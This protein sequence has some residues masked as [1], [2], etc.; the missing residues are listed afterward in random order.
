MVWPVQD[1]MGVLMSISP[2]RRILYPLLLVA[3]WGICFA[4]GIAL[5]S[6]VSSLTVSASTCEPVRWLWFF[7]ITWVC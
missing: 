3:G 5:G 7:K 1:Y 2:M 6:L 4:W